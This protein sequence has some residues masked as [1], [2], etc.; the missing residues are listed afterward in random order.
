[1]Q[2][3]NMGEDPGGV[4]GKLKGVQFDENKFEPNFNRIHIDFPPRLC[5][6]L[7][8]SS[9]IVQPTYSK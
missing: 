1:M 3:K 9:P 7:G 6:G 8:A 5:L 2:E 4:D